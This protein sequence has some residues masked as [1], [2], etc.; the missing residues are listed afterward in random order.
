MVGIL[1]YIGAEGEGEALA[2]ALVG[3]WAWALV[4]GVGE[5]WALVVGVVGEVGNY[6]LV[7]TGY[8]SLRILALE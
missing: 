5:V 1:A 2:W 3:V 6:T 7:D 4:V 8:N